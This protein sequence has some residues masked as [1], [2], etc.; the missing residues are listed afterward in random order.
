MDTLMNNMNYIDE[1]INT[2]TEKIHSWLVWI[3]MIVLLSIILYCV[4]SENHTNHVSN[5][6]KLDM[7]S[8][9]YYS[10]DDV[11]PQL[12]RIIDN[13]SQIKQEVL[14]VRQN[15]WKDWPE[16]QLYGTN[17]SLSHVFKKTKTKPKWNIYPF[18]AFDVTV[19][20]N[21]RSCPYLWE[22]LQRIPGLKV[23]LL[24][25]L[26]PGTKLNTHQGWGGHSNHVIRCHYG[27]EV[28]KGC[29]VSVKENIDDDEEIKLHKQDD[30]ILFDDSRYHYAHNPTDSERI[31]LIVDVQRPKHITT[32]KS[33]I[34]DTKEL[35]QIVDYFRQKNLKVDNPLSTT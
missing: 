35:L 17:D 8:K 10:V 28:P 15:E 18:K 21:C 34:G 33:N 31:V 22:F 24:S 20:E 16:K 9:N 14:K 13:I 12:N 1:R 32:G 19:K 30:W 2:E 27:F 26:G 11:C 4:F 23:A 7:L 29:Y 6:P 25:C 3:L 5:R